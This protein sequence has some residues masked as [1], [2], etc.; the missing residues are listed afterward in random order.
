MFFQKMNLKKKY[1]FRKMNRDILVL[2]FMKMMVELFH[3]IVKG[4]NKIIEKYERDLTNS[5]EIVLQN[6]IVDRKSENNSTN[7]ES[8]NDDDS[9]NQES[10]ND[11]DSTN[12]EPDNDDD[13]RRTTEIMTFIKS[14]RTFYDF[15]NENEKTA[16]M[17]IKDFSDAYKQ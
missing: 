17:A 1:K 11:D 6:P 2:D 15:E 10:D 3:E 7:Q 14:K 16:I 9:T 4:G 5:H 12:Q 8:D 13:S